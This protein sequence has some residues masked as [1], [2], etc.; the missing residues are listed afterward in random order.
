[1]IILDEP[2]AVLTPS[3]TTELFA[4]LRRLAAG[5]DS[6]VFISHKLREVFE[7]ADRITVL[8]QGR[9]TASFDAAHTSSAEVVAAMTGRTNV[10]LGRIERSAPVGGSITLT[11]SG[12]S[13]AATPH[14]AALDD[15]TF[16]IAAGEIL[17]VAGVEGNGQTA[18]ADAIVGTLSAT[19]GRINAGGLDITELTVSARRD[20][21]VGF[22]PEDRHR[23][24][25]PMSGS[26]LEGLAAER[27]RSSPASR[28]WA[29][30]L[31]P[32][33]RS[34]AQ[35]LVSRHSIRT[36]GI[37]AK[38][39]QLSGGNQQKIVIARE[40]EADPV[41]LVLA[42]PTRGVDLG[43]IEFIYEQV[44][45]ATRRG[46][47]VL[48]ISADLDEI[49][50]LSDRV[51]VMYGGRVAAEESATSTSREALGMHMAGMGTEAA[52]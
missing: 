45:E 34:W 38:C 1:V 2:T 11:V 35:E 51:I 29:P 27:I 25:L 8:R 33:I 28:F 36:S 49:L 16:E 4:L 18:L 20:A 30:A 15:V 7:V 26:V 42:Q 48:L 47:A 40:L 22:V 12:L 52:A 14:D 17:G 5:G 23:E 19:G 31:P 10:N 37:D 41:L 44:A 9:T 50:R 46:C 32:A 39:S 21:R 13:T 3:E 6:I 43:A 24:G